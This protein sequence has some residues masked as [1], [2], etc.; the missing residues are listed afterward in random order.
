MIF[1]LH[2]SMTFRLCNRKIKTDFQNLRV[3]G[4]CNLEVLLIEKVVSRLHNSILTSGLHNLKVK[5]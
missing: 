1:R 5:K 2:N 3:L 4:L